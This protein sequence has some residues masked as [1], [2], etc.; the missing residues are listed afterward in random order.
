MRKKYEHMRSFEIYKIDDIDFSQGIRQ[1]TNQLF[2]SRE[3]NAR[4]RKARG[5]FPVDYI[6]SIQYV[7]EGQTFSEGVHKLKSSHCLP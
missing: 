2:T 6:T 7:G 4:K 5:K 1:N 3:K